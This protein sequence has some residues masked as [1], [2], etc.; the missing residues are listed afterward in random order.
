MIRQTIFVATLCLVTVACDN[1]PAEGKVK[2]ETKDVAAHQVVKKIKP[3]DAHVMIDF[4]ETSGKVGF[5]GAKITNKH[6]GNF[7]KFKGTFHI[8]EAKPE[9]S[10]VEVDIDMNSLTIEPA[11]L[12][13]H[14]L[15]ADFFEAEKFPTAKF[16]S[17]AVAPIEGKPGSF[18]VTGQLTLHGK[19]QEI[20]FPAE[21]SASPNSGSVKTE[22]AINRKD[23]DIVYPGMPDDLIADNVLI[24]L[25]ITAKK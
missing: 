6:E 18:N 8:M 12:K 10:K 16:I 1:K 14:L 23:F 4:D 3:A 17:T 25:D 9:A 15:S 5:V 19:T 20:K 7:A 22:F 2:A 24:Q 11:K 13:G 21:L